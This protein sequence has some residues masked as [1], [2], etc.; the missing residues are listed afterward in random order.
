MPTERESQKP[1]DARLPQ[2]PRM[3]AF[4]V[5][6]ISLIVLV[7]AACANPVNQVTMENYSE[8]C[9]NAERN[10]RLDVAVEACRRAWINTRIGALGTEQESTALYN[11]GRVQ[12]KAMKLGDAEASLKRSLELEDALSG[13]ESAKTG[14][15]L[16]ELAAVLF[17]LERADDGLVYVNRLIPIAPQYLGPE[18]RFVASLFYGYAEYSRKGG[19]LDQASRLE[20]AARDLG[21]SRDEFPST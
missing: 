13:A 11:L 3:T 18:R 20:A 19:R 10:G 8:A 9:S 6:A 5:I 17:V 21:F 2:K 14:R 12:K 7:V 4:R 15:R 1:L 16:A